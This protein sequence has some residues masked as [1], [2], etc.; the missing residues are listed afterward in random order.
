MINQNI[1]RTPL[2]KW[3]FQFN[4]TNMSVEDFLFRIE[5]KQSSSNYSWEEIYNNMNNILSEPAEN[6]YWNFRKNHPRA[7]Y[8]SFKI[9]LSERYPSKDNDID[10][11]RKLINRKMRFGESFDDFVDDIERIFYRMEDHPTVSQL[12]NVIRDNA[13]PDISTYIGLAQTNSLAGIKHLGREAE[14]LVNKLN[15]NKSK[16]F[17]K[18]LHEVSNTGSCDTDD[19]HILFIEAFTSPRKEYKIFQ[20]KR[21]KQKFRVNEE[22]QEEKRVYCYGCGKEGVIRSNCSVCAENRKTSE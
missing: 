16:V 17:K 10:S 4:G 15:A 8:A 19:D 1:N 6:W 3:G 21:C 18:N 12:I 11:W 13:T 14:K 9:A 22:T 20:C 5:C 2:D 7:N